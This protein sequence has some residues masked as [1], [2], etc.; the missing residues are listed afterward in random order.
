MMIGGHN[1][2]IDVKKVEWNDAKKVVLDRQET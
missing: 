2:K 1:V